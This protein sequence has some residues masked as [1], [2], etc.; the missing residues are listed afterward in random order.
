ME[1]SNG[2]KQI[3]NKTYRIGNVIVTI[4]EWSFYIVEAI[5]L[6]IAFFTN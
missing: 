3:F 4:A 5:L 1:G 6:V 2:L